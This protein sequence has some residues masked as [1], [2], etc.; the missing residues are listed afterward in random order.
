MTIPA[1]R[2]SPPESYPYD[3]RTFDDEAEIKRDHW[4]DIAPCE[5]VVDVGCC[6]GGYSLPALAQG[7][8]V[9]AFDATDAS[10]RHVAG[11]V[12]LNEWGDH[13]EFRK[14]VLW[15]GGEYPGWMRASFA[16][17]YA[18]TSLP[19]FSTLDEE[20]LGEKVDRIKIDVE[21]AELGVV[22]GGR[23]VLARWKPKLL[24]ESHVGIYPECTA[25]NTFAPLAALLQSLGY[26]VSTRWWGDPVGGRCFIL[27]KRGS[28]A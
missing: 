2:T 10:E 1:F 16:R 19:R 22:R 9:L 5:R 26:E 6:W 11:N 28:G 18:T 15:D 21:G 13:F 7:A 20:L 27:A 4:S 24:I 17:H 3:F 14:R 12:A 25:E 23:S 8:R